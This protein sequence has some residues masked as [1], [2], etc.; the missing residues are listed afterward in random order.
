[1]SEKERE[2]ERD[3]ATEKQRDRETEGQRDREIERQR[4]RDRERERE[5]ERKGG[6]YQIIHKLSNIDFS[7]QKIEI[8]YYRVW[9][10]LF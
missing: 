9:K 5:R 7:N 4:E 2:T 3:R 8:K 1:M 10:S 6:V